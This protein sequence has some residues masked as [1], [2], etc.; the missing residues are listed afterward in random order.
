[1]E[2]ELDSLQAMH[3]YAAIFNYTRVYIPV[4]RPQHW[5]LMEIDNSTRNITYLDSLYRGGDEYIALVES[6]LQQL[7]IVRTQEQPLAWRVLLA[8][9]SA[10]VSLG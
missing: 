10:V 8:V 9:V 5:S 7:E 1:M 4:Q 3:D 6:Y 2:L